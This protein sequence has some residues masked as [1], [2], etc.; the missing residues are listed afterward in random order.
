MTAPSV[1]DIVEKTR[2]VGRDQTQTD[3]FAMDM[4]TAEGL[5]EKRYVGP[6]VLENHLS[7]E[8]HDGRT[9]TS[10]LDCRGRIHADWSCGKLRDLP[11]NRS[12]Y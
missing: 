1:G 10:R 11:P 9:P 7:P 2:Q 5:L 12:E 3:V 8:A 4:E 6:D